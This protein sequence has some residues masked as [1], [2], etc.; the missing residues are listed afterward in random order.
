LKQTLKQPNKVFLTFKKPL[1][2]KFL[3]NLKWDPKKNENE[4]LIIK[5]Q[6]KKLK[7]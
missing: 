5:I 6:E 7:H 2:N 4:I 1:K 3:K